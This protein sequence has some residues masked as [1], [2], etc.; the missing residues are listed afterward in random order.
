M[1]TLSPEVHLIAFA[2]PVLSKT[3]E[4]T[5][6]PLISKTYPFFKAEHSLFGFFYYKKII[7]QTV[8]HFLNNES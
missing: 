6:T 7:I 4:K 5:S 8:I 2:A 3:L 1:F